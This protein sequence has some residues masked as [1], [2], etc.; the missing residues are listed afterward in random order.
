[1]IKGKESMRDKIRHRAES[2]RNIG[3]LTT[4][5]LPEGVELYKPEKGPVE[6]DILPYVVS[7][8]NHPEVKKGEQWYQRN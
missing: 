2:R 5:E 8:D 4:L 3:G 7:V 6:F 1:M